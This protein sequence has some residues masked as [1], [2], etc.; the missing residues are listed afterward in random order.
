MKKMQLPVDGSEQALEAA[1]MVLN[2]PQWSSMVSKL[3]S[4]GGYVRPDLPRRPARRLRSRQQVPP[5]RRP[6]VLLE[7]RHDQLKE[8]G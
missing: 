5:S 6:A 2:G 8:I 7:L 4:P 1:S 3:L